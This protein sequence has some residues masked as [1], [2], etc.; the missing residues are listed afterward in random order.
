MTLIERIGADMTAAMRAKD[1]VRLTALR[2]A[3]AALVNR[4]VERGRALEDTEAEQVVWGL[5]KQRR[6]S[7]EQFEKGGRD[8][9]V[10]REKAELAVLES[11]VPPPPTPAELDEAVSAAIADTGA[12]SP[13]DL[14]KV[15]KAVMARL[16]GRPVDGRDLNERVRRKLT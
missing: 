9:L 6:D 1:Q 14:G 13:K 16:A 2:M 15:M 3:K 11:Y 7:I 5:I 8:D 12:T 4:E 10:A